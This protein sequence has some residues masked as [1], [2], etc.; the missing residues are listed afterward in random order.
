M[1]QVDRWLLP[2]GVDELLP[3]QAVALEHLRRHLLD[4]YR[5]RGYQLVRPPLLEYL[6]ALKVGT[7]NDLA[8]QTFTLTDQL[9]GR[10][11]GLRADLTPQ[12]A[13]M[14]A[15]SLK[16]EAP[17]RLCYCAPVLHSTAKRL[18]E[19]REIDQIGIE[20]FG[21]SAT[22]ADI[23]VIELMIETVQQAGAF[24]SEGVVKLDLGNVKIFRCAA[25]FAGLDTEHENQLCDILQR[26]SIPELNGFVAEKISEPAA[27]KLILAL[28]ALCGSAQVLERAET[29]FRQ[30]PQATSTVLLQALEEL[31][32]VYRYLQ[33]HQPT[34][35][36]YFDLSELRGYDYHTGLVFAIYKA[37]HARSLAQ[38]GRY[39]SIGK[40]FGRARPA[41]GFSSDVRALL[42]LKPLPA[43]PKAIYAPAAEVSKLQDEQ[44]Q[45]LKQYIE[46]LR[47][48]G[49]I[50]IQG[51]DNNDAAMKKECCDRE[52]CWQNKQWQVKPI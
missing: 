6:E 50:V 49:E 36:C 15:H 3:A 18:G 23:E 25:E 11:L 47:A 41:T 7:G 20:L 9:S 8:L 5:S 22:Q 14:D 2:E 24:E 37:G 27:Q 39:D 48:S 28:P 45:S 35:E 17:A 51:L 34:L 42:K 46:H 13:R 19:S 12:V 21:S 31:Q 32:I 30:V 40:S 26:K 4:N 43:L 44:T 52:L 1:T 29:L 33:A 38:G 10:L 16:R